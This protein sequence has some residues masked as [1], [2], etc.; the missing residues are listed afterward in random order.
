MIWGYDYSARL[1]VDVIILVV[2]LSVHFLR[3]HIKNRKNNNEENKSSS[4]CDAEKNDTS[5]ADTNDIS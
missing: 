4:I 1:I 5:V 2:I 3:Q